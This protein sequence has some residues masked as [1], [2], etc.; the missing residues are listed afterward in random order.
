MTQEERTLFLL[1]FSALA[2]DLSKIDRKLRACEEVLKKHPQIESEYQLALSRTHEETL[3][4]LSQT[5]STLQQGLDQ[6]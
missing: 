4:V 1:S 2:T 6:K 3:T 5:I